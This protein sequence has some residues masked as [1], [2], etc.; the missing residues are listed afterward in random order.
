MKPSFLLPLLTCLLVGVSLP[1]QADPRLTVRQEGNVIIVAG[2]LEP[3]VAPAEAWSVLTDYDRFPEFVPGIRLNRVVKDNGSRKLVEQ[4]GELM[5]GT[6]KVPYFGTMQ[7]DEKPSKEMRILFLNG[8]FKDVQGTWQ[9]SG[10][11]PVKLSYEMRMDL[12]KSPYPPAMAHAIAQQQVNTWVAVFSAEME[13]RK[14]RN[15]P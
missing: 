5:A 15:K 11:K 1:V 7:I 12:M 13:R 6:L 10:K 8:L 9:L 14:N 3:D 2:A 4:Q